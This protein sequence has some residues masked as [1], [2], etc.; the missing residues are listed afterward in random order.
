M[1]FENSGDFDAL[2]NYGEQLLNEGW[3]NDK[4]VL[5]AMARAY[6]AR[7]DKQ[8]A[9]ELLN[10]SIEG[11][12]FCEYSK[13]IENGILIDEAIARYALSELYQE[14]GNTAKASEQLNLAYKK[15]KLALGDK[16]SDKVYRK[17]CEN[18]SFKRIAGKKES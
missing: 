18:A 2:F 6:Y 5:N 9:V 16:F 4:V 11:K 8:K 3:D 14:I 12:Y 1:D 15:A 13:P 17:I 10:K 7:G